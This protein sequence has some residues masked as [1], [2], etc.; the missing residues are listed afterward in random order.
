MDHIVGAVTP[1]KRNQ[2]GSVTSSG[3]RRSGATCFKAGCSRWVLFRHEVARGEWVGADVVGFGGPE[4][5]VEAED[6]PPVEAGLVGGAGGLTGSGEPVV[7]AGLLVFPAD[8]LGGFRGPVI[9]HA[10]QGQ[11]VLEAYACLLIAALPQLEEAEVT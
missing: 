8:Q 4:V 6:L 3:S 7:G 10:G 2:A 9:G 11:G 1:L 5:G